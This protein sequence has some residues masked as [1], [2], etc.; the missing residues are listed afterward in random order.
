MF[1]EREREIHRLH[2][3]QAM[4]FPHIYIYMLNR[5]LTLVVFV[6]LYIVFCRFAYVIDNVSVDNLVLKDCYVVL[7]VVIVVAAG[8]L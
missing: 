8:M 3:S 1:R 7:V 2:K 5:H 6:H 4:V